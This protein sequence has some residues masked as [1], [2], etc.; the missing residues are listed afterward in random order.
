MDFASMR[1]PR[2]HEVGLYCGFHGGSI[3]PWGFRAYI[4]PAFKNRQDQALGKIA[5]NS[6]KMDCDQARKYQELPLITHLHI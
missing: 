3:L 2:I 6:V 5:I 4:F 1:Y